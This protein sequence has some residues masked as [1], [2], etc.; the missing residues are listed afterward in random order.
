MLDTLPEAD[1]PGTPAVPPA[2]APRGGRDTYFDGIRALAVVAVL[3]YHW[4]S[5]YLPVFDGGYIGVDV[6]FVLSGF[7]ITSVLWHRPSRQGLGAEYRNFL[8]RR[9]RRLYPAL[10]A[11]LLLGGVAVAVAGKPV[12]VHT[13]VKSAVVALGQASSFVQSASVYE[14]RPF[15]HTWTLSVEWAFYLLWPLVL[16]QAKRRG[17]APERLALLSVQVGALLYAVDLFT[18]SRWF[19]FALTA[20]APQILA[21]CALALWVA[22]G[23]YRPRLPAAVVEMLALCAVGAL[24]WWT[25]FGWTQLTTQYRVIGYPLVTL[26]GVLLCAVPFLSR[27][28]RSPV[29]RLLGWRPVAVLGLASYSL[30]LWHLVAIETIGPRLVDDV[31]MPVLYA[32]VI[33]ATGTTT[34]LSYRYLERPFLRNRSSSLRTRPVGGQLPVS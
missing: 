34:W 5:Q 2:Q 4:V 23:R 33:T 32:L 1:A 16:L 31:S 15:S 21:G 22:S 12:S 14:P 7:V 19:Y 26:C 3:L 28:S 10:L 25:V 18:P 9:V 29:Q 11:M 24:G 20:R 30:Y 8:G 13:T 6:F 27:G 17:V